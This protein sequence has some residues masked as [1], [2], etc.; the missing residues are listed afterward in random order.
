[1][2]RYNIRITL[3]DGNIVEA[4]VTADSCDE[5]VAMVKESP[6]FRK[7]AS[8]SGI[9][10]IEPLSVDIQEPS[11]AGYT[12]MQDGDTCSCADIVSGAVIAWKAGDFNGT[13]EVVSAPDAA[14]RCRLLRS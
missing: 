11:A 13:Q 4:S 3:T 9:E 2:E 8:A 1:M 7:F 12:V 6:E 14:A 5:A 10:S